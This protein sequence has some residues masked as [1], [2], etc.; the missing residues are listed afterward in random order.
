[1]WVSQIKPFCAYAHQIAMGSPELV[2]RTPPVA[3]GAIPPCMAQGRLSAVP[4]R[5]KKTS[6]L[7]S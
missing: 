1:M 7:V 4:R 2:A 3:S 5:K 6:K